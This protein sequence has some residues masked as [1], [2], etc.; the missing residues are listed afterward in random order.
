MNENQIKRAIQ[1]IRDRKRFIENSFFYT[2]SIRYQG[3]DSGI[4]PAKYL[5]VFPGMGYEDRT[6]VVDKGMTPA[7][8]WYAPAD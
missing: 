5:G 2:P 6:T 1:S 4:S 7:V 3:D 8:A